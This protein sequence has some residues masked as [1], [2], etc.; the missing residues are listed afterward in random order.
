[1][2]IETLSITNHFFKPIRSHSHPPLLALHSHRRM[3]SSLLRASMS[4]FSSRAILPPPP[5][6]SAPE[7]TLH[8]LCHTP[9]R[10]ACTCLWL[11]SSLPSPHLPFSPLLPS[12]NVPPALLCLTALL[13]LQSLTFLQETRDS[14]PFPGRVGGGAPP[15]PGSPATPECPR[16]PLHAG[17]CYHLS[18]SVLARLRP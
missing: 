2:F 17:A 1:M 10:H 9:E 13:I 7:V 3:C 12:L 15:H 5:G 6:L 11:L 18:L 16:C 4:T 14:P 8:S